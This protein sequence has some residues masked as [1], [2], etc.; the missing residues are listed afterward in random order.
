MACADRIYHGKV[1]ARGKF[2]WFGLSNFE[3][4]SNVQQR[5]RRSV[6]LVA[7]VDENDVTCVRELRNILDV[8]QLYFAAELNKLIRDGTYGMTIICGRP[9][10]VQ[11]YFDSGFKFLKKIL[12]R[13][14]TLAYLALK[15]GRLQE[16]NTICSARLCYCVK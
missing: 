5:Q 9:T 15:F 11:P 14:Y 4:T 1:A 7:D 13:H 2:P 16:I 6:N 12:C 3:T 8:W 10:V